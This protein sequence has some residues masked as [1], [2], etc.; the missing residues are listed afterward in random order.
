[1]AT[2]ARHHTGDRLGTGA[3]LKHGHQSAKYA[4]ALTAET[5]LQHC[6]AVHPV[7]DPGDGAPRRLVLKPAPPMI[8]LRC[9]QLR[10]VRVRR[11][12]GL[13]GGVPQSLGFLLGHAGAE[14][15]VIQRSAAGGR[16][17]LWAQ[18]RGPFSELLRASLRRVVSVIRRRNHC[19]AA[20]DAGSRLGRVGGPLR[21]GVQSRRD[22]GGGTAFGGSSGY[23]DRRRGLRNILSCSVPPA[24][25]QYRRKREGGNSAHRPSGT[26]HKRPQYPAQ[27]L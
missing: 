8:N 21:I 12:T 3:M 13:A 7:S 1:M 17:Y 14:D 16:V 24:E 9:L 4:S 6:R 2:T 27:P 10:D 23:H 15:D 25:H 5:R 26:R 11:R 22:C 20:S 19:P 18:M